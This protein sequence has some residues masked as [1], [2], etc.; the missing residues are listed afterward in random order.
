MMGLEMIE[1]SVRKLFCCLIRIKE[2]CIRKFKEGSVRKLFCCL[3]RIK[4]PCIRKFKELTRPEILG[5]LQT[6]LKTTVEQQSNS[7][8]GYKIQTKFQQNNSST[9]TQWTPLPKKSTVALGYPIFARCPLEPFNL[10]EI[11]TVLQLLPVFTTEFTGLLTPLT[12]LNGLRYMSNFN[13]PMMGPELAT[14][15]LKRSALAIELNSSKLF[16]GRSW[17]YPVGVLH[18]YIFIIS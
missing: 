17:V 3:I 15:R 13:M 16:L 6:A 18:H 8:G 12:C 10:S 1:G 4:E 11:F 9:L 5:I 14:S 2:P 7:R